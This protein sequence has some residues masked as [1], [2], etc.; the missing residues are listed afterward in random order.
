MGNNLLE[1]SPLNLQ[2]HPPEKD[3]RGNHQELRDQFGRQIT[4]LRIS[5]TDRCNLRCV[6]CMPPGGIVKQ[7]HHAIM[8]YEEIA[9]V[10]Q[11]A[12]EYGVKAV[13][14]TGGE[15]LVRPELYKLVRMIADIPQIEDISLTTNA[16]LLEK[17]AP[18]LVDAGLKRVNISLD[19]LQEQKFKHITRYGSLDQVWRGIESAE[20]SGLSPIKI[21]TVTMRGINDDEILSLAKLTL[22]HPWQVRFIELMP[23]GNQ[24]P[25][26]E[27][28][29]TPREAYIPVQEIK[30]ILEPLGLQPVEKTVGSGPAREFIIPGAPGTV[31]FISPLGE[32]FC[33]TCNRVRLTA[34]GNLRPCLLSDVEVSV[35]EELRAGR[36]ILPVLQKVLAVKPEKHEL[37]LNHLPEERNMKEIGG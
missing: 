36:P 1:N 15:P 33:S 26:G 8:R 14:I 9:E 21:N 30:S 6:Y 12:A 2:A 34:D 20:H 13:R 17:Q 35:L 37:D 28:F 4:Y 29:P 5:V 3:S 22:E 10:V 16:M 11:V 25:W 27:D 18:L 23:I 24:V 7:S 32:H 19:T 31:G